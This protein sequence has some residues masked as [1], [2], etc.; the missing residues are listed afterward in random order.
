[1]TTAITPP[2]INHGDRPLFSPSKSSVGGGVVMQVGSLRRS[3][4]SAGFFG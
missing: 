1:M 4:R 2:M 3:S